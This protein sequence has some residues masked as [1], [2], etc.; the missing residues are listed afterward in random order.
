MVLDCERRVTIPGPAE[1]FSKC[2]GLSTSFEVNWVGGGEGAG[3]V[4]LWT[5]K[6]IYLEPTQYFLAQLQ[7][8]D[9]FVNSLRNEK[10]VSNKK[11]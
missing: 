9:H 8:I 7:L 4:G 6:M 10:G 11:A 2:G 5:S 3:V 1:Q